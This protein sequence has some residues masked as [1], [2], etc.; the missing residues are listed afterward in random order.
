MPIM[1][2]CSGNHC[3]N[4]NSRGNGG[5]PATNEREIE[6]TD[7]LKILNSFLES[8]Y[9]SCTNFPIVVGHQSG[10]GFFLRMVP[11]LDWNGQF[12]HM[13]WSISNTNTYHPA[14]I[15]PPQPAWIPPNN[16]RHHD[17]SY[18]STADLTDIQPQ[19]ATLVRCHHTCQETNIH[20]ISNVQT[21]LFRIGFWEAKPFRPK[22]DGRTWQ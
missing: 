18:I 2:T 11:H 19:R 3:S 9:S 16:T 14:L 5:N 17:T 13:P 21:D 1:M 4:Q 20:I 7:G 12:Q 6:V 8:Y 22:V 10:T 15:W